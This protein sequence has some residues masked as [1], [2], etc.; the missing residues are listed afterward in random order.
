MEGSIQKPINDSNDSN[1]N[2]SIQLNE[3]KKRVLKCEQE[4]KFC[5][6]IF[7]FFSSF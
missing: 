3:E 5:Q 7:N 6:L 4:R 1:N 2:E